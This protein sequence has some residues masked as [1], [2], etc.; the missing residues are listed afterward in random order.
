MSSYWPFE[1]GIGQT[2]VDIS[3][4][5]MGTFIGNVGWVPG[6]IGTYAVSL[7]GASYVDVGVLSVSG[8]I[9]LAAWVKP[10]SFPS[11]STVIGNFDA[12]VSGEQYELSYRAD[13]SFFYFYTQDINS[14]SWKSPAGLLTLNTWSHI[15]V[16]RDTLNNVVLYF[17]GSPVNATLNGTPGTP[18][19]TPFSATA[20]GRPGSL[21]SQYVTGQIDE[22][23]IDTFVRSAVSIAQLAV[24]P[25]L[26]NFDA[27]PTSGPVPLTVQFVDLSIAA[28]TAWQW[29]FGDGNTSILQN[30][31]NTYT[32]PGAY[33]VTLTVNGNST[34]LKPT[35]IAPAAVAEMRRAW[36]SRMVRRVK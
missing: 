36:I 15:A 25:S 16:T 3:G 26:A 1:E 22:V 8:A 20:I 24:P 30:P 31:F 19:A 33:N 6:R 32:A 5:N 29:S 17:N 35:F 27:Y 23:H 14:P 18:I 21:N 7:D 10:S 2:T 13:G 9:T 28:P 4:Q 11:I 34:L 12:A